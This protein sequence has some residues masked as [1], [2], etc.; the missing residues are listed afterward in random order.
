MTTDAL[1]H[2][3]LGRGFVSNEGAFGLHTVR[4]LATSLCLTK[5]DPSQQVLSSLVNTALAGL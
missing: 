2:A 4:D 3:Y 1:Q 5:P